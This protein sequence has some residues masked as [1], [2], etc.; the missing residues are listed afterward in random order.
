MS[1]M[2]WSGY[3][4][5]SA[6]ITKREVIIDLSDECNEMLLPECRHTYA[7]VYTAMCH[8]IQWFT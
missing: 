7:G 4:N 8:I 2:N 3:Q 5:D 6:V 1:A